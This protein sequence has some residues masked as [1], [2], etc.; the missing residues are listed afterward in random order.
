MEF[1]LEPCSQVDGTVY[2][3]EIPNVGSGTATLYVLN[4]GGQPSKPATGDFSY[5]FTNHTV[6]VF[7]EDG[8]RT[9]TVKEVES[10][11]WNP[12]KNGSV[13]CFSKRG[14]PFWMPA[15]EDGEWD[16]GFRSVEEVL[17]KFM[18]QF[19]DK[20]FRVPERPSKCEVGS[21]SL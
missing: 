10:P 4:G 21:Q 11:M 12:K 3:A 9:V 13:M 20:L 1:V 19:D 6:Q 2:S 7:H 17:L 15:D 8:W 18:E 16:C 5:D 14:L